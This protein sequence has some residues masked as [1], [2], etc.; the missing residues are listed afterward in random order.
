MFTKGNFDIL[1]LQETRTD[2][3]EKEIKKWTKI[4]NSKSIYLTSFGTRAVG[5]GIIVKNNETFN[6]LH[7][8]K[9]P[10]GRYVGIIGDHEEGKFLVLSFYS[11]S[12]A[13]EIKDFVINQIYTKLND[14]GEDLPQFILCGGDT[15]TVFSSLDKQGG[16]QTFKH[17]AIHAFEQK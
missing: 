4:F 10:L 3:S 13:R 9:D 16:N 8:F 6:V 1:L 7:Q 12:I 17:E 15:N 2:G 14:L 5:T 11:P